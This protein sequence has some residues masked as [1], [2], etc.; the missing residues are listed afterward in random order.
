MLTGRNNVPRAYFRYDRPEPRLAERVLFASQSAFCRL[1]AADS[2]GMLPCPVSLMG[3]LER[4]VLAQDVLF[5]L[6][7]IHG[8]GEICYDFLRITPFSE[9]DISRCE[10]A[11]ESLRAADR[12]DMGALGRRLDSASAVRDAIP[13]LQGSNPLGRALRRGAEMDWAKRWDRRSAYLPLGCPSRA[14]DTL[15]TAGFVE[16]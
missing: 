13:L 5:L 10:P 8:A 14:V 3:V 6:E 1:T 2:S 15:V 16:W 9:S 4:E 12:I 7:D 11:R